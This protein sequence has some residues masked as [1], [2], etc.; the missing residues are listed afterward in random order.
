[1]TEARPSAG[2][3]AAR[4]G[5]AWTGRR[6]LAQAAAARAASANADVRAAAPPTPAG[7]VHTHSRRF[8]GPLPTEW[9]Q[10]ATDDRAGDADD[11]V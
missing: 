6:P 2:H 5:C 1:M 9:R 8:G 3:L 7:K 4:R 10:A 11:E